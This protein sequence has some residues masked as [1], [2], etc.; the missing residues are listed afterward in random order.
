MGLDQRIGNY[1]DNN[2]FEYNI[3][4]LSKDT[5]QLRAKYIFKSENY[6]NLAKAI[7]RLFK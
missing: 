4:R 2:L 5:N 7:K 6:K 3:Y 1:Y